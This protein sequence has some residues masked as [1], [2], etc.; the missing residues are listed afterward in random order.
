MD[1]KEPPDHHRYSW[2]AFYPDTVRFLLRAIAFYVERLEAEQRTLEA[3]PELMALLTVE[4]RREFR[5]GRDCDHAKRIQLWLQEHLD[6]ANGDIDVDIS[7]DH[8]TV[9]FLKSVGLLYLAHLK[10]RRN[11]ISQTPDL[12]ANTLA[13][14]DREITKSEEFLNNAGVFSNA[15]TIPLLV[16]ERDVCS[17]PTGEQEAQPTLRRA[18]RPSPVIIESIE[19]LDQ[20]LRS[21]CLDLFQ[22]FKESGEHARQDTVISEA[23]RILEHRLRAAIKAADTVTGK[24]LAIAAFS[25]TN[26]VLRISSIPGEQTAVQLLFQGAFGFIRNPVHHKLLTDLSADRVLQVLGFVDYLISIINAAERR[27]DPR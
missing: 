21:R 27:A 7:L 16:P 24:D 25:G 18:S 13:A 26:P 19:I 3:D 4:T 9:R 11:A 22:Q 12:S 8:A 15:S 14:I 23:T 1:S 20:E 10:N 6:K 17:V 5:I 2:V